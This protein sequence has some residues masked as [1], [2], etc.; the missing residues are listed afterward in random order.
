[1]TP[2]QD[3]T[4]LEWV[5]HLAGDIDGR[6]DVR[7]GKA[8]DREELGRHRGSRSRRVKVVVGWVDRGSGKVL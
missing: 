2:R 7:G 8:Q 4:L 3:A 6:S 5:A 1:M